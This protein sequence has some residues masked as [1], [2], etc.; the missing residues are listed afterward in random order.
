MRR[1]KSLFIALASILIV[2]VIT[3]LQEKGS[4]QTWSGAAQGKRIHGRVISRYGPVKNARVRVAGDESYALTNTRGEFVFPTDHLSEAR[5]LVTAGKEGWFN[6]GQIGAGSGLI[7][8]IFLN[9]VYLNDR[10]DYRFISPVTCSRCHAKLTRYWD[11]SKM[12]HTSSNPKV[13][14]MFYGTD[15][16]NRPG[17]GP[18]FRLDNPRSNGNCIT[19]HAPSFAV[20][21]PW[22]QDLKGALQSPLTEWDGISCEYCHKVRKVFPDKTKPSGYSALLERQSAYSGSSILVFGPYDD[23]VVPPM[24]ASYNPVYD[25]A[26][27]CSTCHSHRK[28]LGKGK[29]WDRRK[30]YSDAEWRGFG[31]EDDTFLPIQTTYQEFKLWQ[32]QLSP[33]DPN[34]GKTC[35]EC[36]MSWRKEMLPYDNYVVDGMARNMWGTYRS[37]QNIRPHHFDGGTETQ[38]K[39][40]LSMELEGEIEGK[41]LN[42]DVYIT[43]TNGGHWVP[44]GETMRSVMLLL[45]VF[46]S[47]GKPLKMIN[48]SVLPDWTGRGDLE[49]GNYADLPGAVFARVLQDEEGNIHVPFWQATRIA[50]DTRIRQKST[51]T[52]KWVFALEDPEDEPTVEAKLIYRPV[53]RP[54]AEKKK[55]HVQDI[56]IVSKV[57]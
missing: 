53:I 20:S 11:Q 22:S 56:L 27:F 49:A 6:N 55:W 26:E 45:R 51:S 50:S 15:A 21:S 31:L 41:K 7:R 10:S 28:K 48:G 4:A 18:G 17:I 38:L 37:A 33:D 44:T 47:R 24:A 14:D 29:T 19:C 1:K 3:Y 57:W 2:S 32:E 40:A 16:Y 35:Q 39:T 25:K 30:V 23:V 46:D 5:I 9:P 34:K 52:L 54:W 43:N 12:A 8:D 13:Q 42:V 36:H